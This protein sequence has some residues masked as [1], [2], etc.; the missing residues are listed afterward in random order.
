MSD[1]A[2]IRRPRMTGGQRRTVGVGD[3]I[4]AVSSY[5][6]TKMTD[7][8]NAGDMRK[9]LAALRAVG[10]VEPGTIPPARALRLADD[11]CA[12]RQAGG[13]TQGLALLDSFLTVR[14]EPYRAAMSSPLLP[15]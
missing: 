9:H 2:P 7:N 11:P 5:G 10:G 12:H 14:G 13:R 15:K 6:V 1:T 8:V 3:L 4:S